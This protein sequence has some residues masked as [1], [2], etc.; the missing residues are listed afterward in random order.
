MNHSWSE[1]VKV[2]AWFGLLCA[3][4]LLLLLATFVPENI[5]ALQGVIFLGV[6]FTYALRD[7]DVLAPGVWLVAGIWFTHF[8]V[9]NLQEMD[10]VALFSGQTVAAISSYFIAFVLIHELLSSKAGAKP[11]QLEIT[12][13]D[14]R[15]C[16]LAYW[17]LTLA[18]LMNCLFFVVIFRGTKTDSYL[19]G[20]YRLQFVQEWYVVAFVASLI[21]RVVR[22]GR[23]W[24]HVIQGVAFAVF[25]VLSTGTRGIFVG[26]AFTSALVLYRFKKVRLP[27]LLGG[28]AAVL[29]A[30]TI[31]NEYRNFFAAEA[32]VAVSQGSVEERSIVVS[33]LSG[34]PFYAGRNFDQIVDYVD[35][36]GQMQPNQFLVDVALSVLPGSVLPVE[37]S[38]L[39]F[40]KT[41]Y[42][43]VFEKG[44]GVGYSLLGSIY[45][46]A[47]LA[48]A[49][50]FLCLL[51]F[52]YHWLW[53]RSQANWIVL[54]WLVCCVPFTIVG[55]RDD[56]GALIGT[57]LRAIGPPLILIWFS[58]QLFSIHRRRARGKDGSVSLE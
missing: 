48:S 6:L 10:L 18:Q 49:L 5:Y 57:Q 11:G 27:L 35:H 46:P 30:F 14:E 29:V 56:I 12:D 33:I 44:G 1:L 53:T 22:R 26:V 25:S 55:M 39:W 43:D 50:P 17:L 58:K 37:H 51:A 42:A 8:S 16:R 23:F 28:V 36:G 38:T 4:L 3:A 31:L 9:L 21:C 41:F 52:Y 20:F 13:D 45:T 54:L 32:V 19:T 40:N 24:P 47:G 2:L 34:E 15:G 7:Q